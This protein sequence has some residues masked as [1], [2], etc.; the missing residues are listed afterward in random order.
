MEGIQG[1]VLGVKLKHLDNWT[2]GRRKV[3]AK[4]KELLDNIKEL[5]LPEE[6]PNVKHVYH[7]Y[8][9]R[10]NGK[11]LEKREKIRNKLQTFLS[12]NGIASGLHYPVP[13]H[14]QKCFSYLGY[15]K[16]DFPVTEDLA[17]SS[18][19]LPMFPELKDEQVEYVALK[20]REFFR[21]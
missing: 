3:A 21:K 7:L 17:Q 6:L 10:V 20:I 18:L 4:Y 12:E 8:V 1:A 2:N 13:L 5:L 19:S 11:S 15:N 16:G 14:L 9:V